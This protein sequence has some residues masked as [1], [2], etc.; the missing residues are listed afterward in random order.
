M[1]CAHAGCRCEVGAGESVCGDH[2]REHA[3]QT[4]HGDHACECGHA[5]CESPG[6]GRSTEDDI[7]AAFD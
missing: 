2:C 4:E 7:Q 1:S 6:A 5:A 3:G